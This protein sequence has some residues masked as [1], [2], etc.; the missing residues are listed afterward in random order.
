M[1]E[2]KPNQGKKGKESMKNLTFTSCSSKSTTSTKSTTATTSTITTTTATSTMDDR[3]ETRDSCYFPG[4]R[5]DANCDCEICLASITATL[6]LMPMGIQKSTLTK[7]S[8]SKSMAETT[9]VSLKSS[10][11][12]PP[13]KETHRIELTPPLKSTAKSNLF[14]RTEKKRKKKWVW[15]CGFWGFLLVIMCVGFAAEHEFSRVV[16]GVL[17]PELSPQMM[18]RIREEYWVGRD[19]NEKLECLQG[20]L[21]KIVDGEV[22]NCSLV[23]SNWQLS[24]IGLILR[25]RCTL[26]KSMAEEVSVWGWPLQT[27]GL[28]STGLSSISLAIL[29]GRVT[30]WPNGKMGFIV[31]KASNSSTWLLGRFSASAIQLDPNTWILEYKVSPVLENSRLLSAAMQFFKFRFSHIL[32]SMKQRLVVPLPAFADHLLYTDNSEEGFAH[33]T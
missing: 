21:G 28:I 29:S 4:C 27:S 10:I 7:L 20:N 33:P 14:G 2:S 13:R 25:S 5:K 24:E 8:A 6:D 3:S 22:K 30:E 32:H 12:T 1:T 18:E 9:P 26:Y 17:K 31:R 11:S 23:K 15:G 19:L 16:S